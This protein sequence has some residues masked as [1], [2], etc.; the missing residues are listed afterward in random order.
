M[1]GEMVVEKPCNE[2]MLLYELLEMLGKVA[3]MY[4]VDL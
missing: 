2:G 3:H 1:L 4:M